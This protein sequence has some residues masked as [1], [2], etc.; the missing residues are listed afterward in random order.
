MTDDT[1]RDSPAEAR[2]QDDALPLVSVLTPVIRAGAIM[3]GA[4]A[5]I[6]TVQRVSNSMLLSAHPRHVHILV[7]HNA[8]MITIARETKNV[9]PVQSIDGHGVDF[10][11]VGAVYRLAKAIHRTQRIP[12]ACASASTLPG[13]YAFKAMTGFM[14]F[15]ENQD[16]GVFFQAWRIFLT[17]LCI[18]MALGLVLPSLCLRIDRRT[19]T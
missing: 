19:L 3:F 16:P 10:N 12:P 14:P 11:K 2:A 13:T 7:A 17:M 6:V 15:A 4:G 8:L 5:E 1:S 9:T 18:L